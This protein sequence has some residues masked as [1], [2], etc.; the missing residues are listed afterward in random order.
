ML[1]AA[2]RKFGPEREIEAHFNDETG[3][4]ELFE[5][6]TVVAGEPANDAHISLE[7]AHRHDPD[8]EVGDQI[9]V[10]L[11]TAEFGRI[12]AQ[13]AKQVISS[14]SARPSATTSTTSTRT[15]RASSSRGI[16]RRFERGNLIVD[17]GRA[18]AMLP[19]REQVP[20]ETYRAGDRIAPTCSTSIATR[21]ARRSSCRAR[22]RACSRSCSSRRCRR[23]TRRSCASRARRASRARARRSPSSSRDRDVDPVGA[24]VGMK[25]WRVQAVV[26]ELRGEKIDIVPYDDDPARFV[27]NAIAP[28]E[29][30]RV[31]IDAEGAP[32]GADRPRRQA[33]A[34]DRQEGPERA[35]RV[36]AHRLADR[37]QERDLH[38]RGAGRARAGALGRRRA[39]RA[40]RRRSCSTTASRQPRRARAMP[41]WSCSTADSRASTPRAPR[42]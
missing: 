41:S 40:T 2:R 25:G 10:K 4:V 3:E 15:A 11:D 13:T 31:I 18:E 19:V 30:S 37:H 5:F 34:R 33:V 39:G 26:Q 17:L 35:P 42:P 6:K 12:A 21:A 38:A 9:G 27:C 1:T 20:R 22:T 29:V 8:A 23:S 32:H 28:A 36:A 7:D 14:A 16:V 24:C